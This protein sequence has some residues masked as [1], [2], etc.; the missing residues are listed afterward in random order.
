MPLVTPKSIK[1]AYNLLKVT[2]FAGV[3]MPHASRFKFM[4]KRMR[5]YHGWYDDRPKVKTPVFIVD[6]QITEVPLF[7]Y[8]VAH[9]CC[10][11]AHDHNGK[12]DHDLH[13][14]NFNALARI[15]EHEMGWK[16]GSV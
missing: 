12:C 3:K 4:A 5:N 2:A 7:L 9:E 8:T 10:H 13:D 1:A 11:V 16:K 6:T 15:V 14:E